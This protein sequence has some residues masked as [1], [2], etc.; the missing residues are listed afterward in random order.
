MGAKNSRPS[1]TSYVPE[2]NVE[3]VFEDIT[4]HFDGLSRE[5]RDKLNQ[6]LDIK[7]GI[8]NE[9]AS[10]FNYS[11]IVGQPKLD[12]HVF[13]DF[14]RYFASTIRHKHLLP[15]GYKFFGNDNHGKILKFLLRYNAF[16]TPALTVKHDHDGNRLWVIKTLD[17]N[18]STWYS[19]IVTAYDPSFPRVNVVLGGEMLDV[20]S[21]EVYINGDDRT[22]DIDEEHVLRYLLVTLC[23]FAEVVHALIHIFDVILTTALLHATQHDD[24]QSLWAQQFADNTNLQYLEAKLSLFNSDGA[25]NNVG[26]HSQTSLLRPIAKD[27]LTQWLRFHSA[28]DVVRHFLFSGI[29]ATGTDQDIREVHE[30]SLFLAEWR[31]HAA[32]LPEY[33]R[34]LLYVFNRRH[35]YS[36]EVTND[37]ITSYMHSIGRHVSTITTLHSW[38]ELMGAFALLHGNTLSMTRLLMTPAI[39]RYLGSGTHAHDYTADD[40]LLLEKLSNTVMKLEPGRYFFSGSTL[41]TPVGYPLLQAVMNKYDGLISGTKLSYY[42]QMME[43]E[44][45]VRDYG[46]IM[47][48][49]CPDG[50][51]G[52]QITLSTY[53]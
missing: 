28:E 37:N 42:M 35:Q 43:N 34:E 17:T 3:L 21:Y 52:K 39:F 4:L 24:V 27:L 51:D 10:T 45:M 8:L 18:H 11:S 16:F 38:V 14:H 15:R 12:T 30:G 26:F 48:D 41:A 50:V 1:P 23:Y 25:I 36:V 9:R 33:G 19:K 40:A 6:Q 20:V 5:L 49:Y 29:Y 44:D 47:T 53:L 46:W 31:K 32:L 7:E 22:E 2:S 13:D